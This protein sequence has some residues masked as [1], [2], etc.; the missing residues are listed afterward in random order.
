MQIVASCQFRDCTPAMTT[1]SHVPVQSHCPV[2]KSCSSA[3]LSRQ[4]IPLIQSPT[5]LPL[6]SHFEGGTDQSILLTYLD[7]LEVLFV[8]LHIRLLCRA[9]S[10]LGRRS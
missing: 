1:K 6:L 8:Y 5:P 3:T 7:S 9:I 4:F 10:E 2:L